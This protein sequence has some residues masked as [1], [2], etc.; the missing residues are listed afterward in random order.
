MTSVDAGIYRRRA[1]DPAASDLCR[2]ARDR[3]AIC[4]GVMQAPPTPDR[5]ALW[6]ITAAV[7]VVLGVLLAV[8]TLTS[9]SPVDGGLEPAPGRLL[10]ASPGL[11]DPNFAQTVV[12]LTEVDDAGAMGVILNRPTEVPLE[13]VLPWVSELDDRADLLSVGGPVM[14]DRLVVL[15]R[16]DREPPASFH[17]FADVWMTGDAQTLRL[18]LEEGIAESDLRAFT[19]FAGWAPGQLEW[20]IA[21]G[22]WEVHPARVADVFGGNLHRLWRDLVDRTPPQQA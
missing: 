4:W 14:S 17:V 5:P 1:C 15:M 20:E 22:G 2:H 18:L 11:L 8:A 12:L 19:G 21:R 6:R 9:G 3:G 7:L 13:D 10:V 16:R